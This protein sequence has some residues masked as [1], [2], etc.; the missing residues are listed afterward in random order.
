MAENK[1]WIFEKHSH[2]EDAVIKNAGESLVLCHR[3]SQLIII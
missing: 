1:L 2:N 3:F